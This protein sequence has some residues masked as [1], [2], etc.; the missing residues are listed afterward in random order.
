MPNIIVS[1]FCKSRQTVDSGLSYYAG[2]A[3]QLVEIT[4]NNWPNKRWGYRGE[5]GGIVEVDIPAAFIDS[6]YSGVITLNNGDDLVGNF[7]SRVDGEEPRLSY[8]SKDGRPTVALSGYIVL[9]QSAVLEHP[10]L[11]PND[12]NNWE[13]IT[14]NCAPTLE[15]TPINPWTLMHNHFGSDGGT[16][17]NMSNDIFVKSLQEA[18]VYWKDKAMCNSSS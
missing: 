16:D 8:Y 11:D 18:F 15:P 5:N 14:I 7:N 4:L 2:T 3:D 12:P 10:S 13:I 6:F 1:D 17:T 9:Y